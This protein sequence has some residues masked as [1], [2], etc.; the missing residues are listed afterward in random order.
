VKINAVSE[1]PAAT[2]DPAPER[3]SRYDRS[4]GG[5]LAAMIVTVLFVAAYVG[6]RALTRDQPDLEPD[7]D[8]AS[9]VAYLQ[10]ADVQVAYPRELPS[11]WRANAIHFVRGSP[12]QWR[13]GLLTD[14]DEFVGVVQQEADLDD[15]LTKYVDE[16]PSQ[17]ED[18]APANSLGATVWQTWSDAGGDHAF[19]TVLGSGPLD[20]QTVLVYGSAPVADLERVLRALTLD[21]VSG[22]VSASDCDTDEFS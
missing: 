9:C 14:G 8:Y 2:P 5:L 4:F 13:I 22:G 10:E 19:S 7:V 11:G 1:E 6:F 20:G 12:P 21:P 17:G 15:L 16:S 18:T 3:P